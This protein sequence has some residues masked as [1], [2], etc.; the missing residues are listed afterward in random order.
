[1]LPLEQRIDLLEKQIETLQ[2]SYTRLLQWLIA[3]N[4]GKTKMCQQELNNLDN[5]KQK[6]P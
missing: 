1:M 6:G 4:A 2:V 3:L 5:L